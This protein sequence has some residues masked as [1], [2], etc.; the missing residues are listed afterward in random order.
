M[1]INL[2]YDLEKDVENFLKSF[3]SVNNKTPT[4]LQDLYIA[5]IGEINPL[6]VSSFLQKQA[7][8][9]P[10]KLKTTELSWKRVEEKV[11]SRLENFFEIS[12]QLDIIIYLSTNSRCTYNIQENYFFVYI[13]SENPNGIIIHELMH[14]YTWLSLY[15]ELTEHGVSKEKYND[16]KES[17][18]ELIN[19][20]FQDL[21]GEYYDKGYSQH[22]EIRQR[23]NRL[24]KEGKN[25]K[26]IVKEL[27]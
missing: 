12:L 7:I 10:E 27:Y 5:T 15:K 11:I 14:F 16:I 25:I 8:N 26:D 1:Q 4:K 23:V 6:K 3:N 18:T 20:D 13:N 21:L 19:T 9:I 24:R 22:A 2:K 17:L